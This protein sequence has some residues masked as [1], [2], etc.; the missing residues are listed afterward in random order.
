MPKEIRKVKNAV[1]NIIS[2]V[3]SFIVENAVIILHVINHRSYG[4]LLIL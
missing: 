1:N 3:R 4:L 2:Y